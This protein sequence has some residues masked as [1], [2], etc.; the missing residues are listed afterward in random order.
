M[1][2]GAGRQVRIKVSNIDKSLV[3]PGKKMSQRSKARGS[4]QKSSSEN[5]SSLAYNPRQM[6]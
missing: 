2:G 1:E 3:D 6:L 4:R 5:L